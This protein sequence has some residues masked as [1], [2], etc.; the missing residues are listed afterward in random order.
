MN[1]IFKLKQIFPEV[2]FELGDIGQLEHLIGEVDEAKIEFEAGNRSDYLL[3]LV[4]V[5][6]TAMN[7]LYKAG[8]SHHEINDGLKEVR[9]KNN[10]R[11]YYK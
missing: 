1:E 8:Y 7:A 11:K 10:L 6:H 4:D 3:E 2:K 5:A 9:T